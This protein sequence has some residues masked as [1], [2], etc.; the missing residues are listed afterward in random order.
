ML[1]VNGELMGVFS[2]FLKL[3]EEFPVYW[4]SRSV[5]YKKLSSCDEYLSGSTVIKRVN[6][7]DKSK[8]GFNDGTK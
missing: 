1:M 7:N 4:K 8:Y 2:S 6:I 5:I 3:L